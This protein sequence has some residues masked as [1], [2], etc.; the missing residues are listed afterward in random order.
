MSGIQDRGKGITQES[1]ESQAHRFTE[2][3]GFPRLSQLPCFG[4]PLKDG[5]VVGVLIRHQKPAARGIQRE[6][7]GPLSSTRCLLQKRE[8][9]SFGGD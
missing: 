1:E 2:G 8:L 5:D 3:E 6:M 7:A 4:V 9:S